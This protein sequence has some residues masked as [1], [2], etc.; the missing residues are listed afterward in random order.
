MSQ[1]RG[2]FERLWIAGLVALGLVFV[3]TYLVVALLRLSHPFELE[4]MEGAMVDHVLR[5]MSGDAL[6]VEPTLEF[7]PFIYP[8]G[9]YW[10]SAVVSKI[11]GEGFLPLRLVSI[12]ASIAG[13]A[14]LCA[15]GVRATNRRSMGLLAA[16]LFVA[17]YRRGDAWLDLGRVDS[18]FLALILGA[19]YCISLEPNLRNRVLAAVLL[20][21]AFVT[22]QTTL[23]IAG[24]LLV[25]AL[26]ADRGRIRF[27]LPALFSGLTIAF[28]L[29]MNSATNHWFG[30]Y[31]FV[32]PERHEWS[33]PMLTRFWTSDLF[34]VFL[35][36]LLLGSAGM[37]QLLRSSHRT[38]IVSIFALGIGLVGSSWLS[39]L[40][41]G[42]H[43]NVLI[44]A[45][46]FLALASV[47][48]LHGMTEGSKSFLSR[49]SALGLMTI[50]FALLAYD[51]RN[52][53]PTEA[54]V[55]AGRRFE[56]RLESVDGDVLIPA[57]GY[58]ATRM[59]KTMTAH[60]MAIF[61]VLRD[62]DDEAA[63]SLTRDIERALAAMRYSAIVLDYSWEFEELIEDGY[64][65]PTPALEDSDALIPVSGV[66]T[67][68]T[69]VYSKP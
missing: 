11:V 55:E 21:F 14:L 38:Q 64:A 51:P 8:P 54:D 10:I 57:H 3:A 31:V 30:Y 69:R 33:F 67:R 2:A 47:I 22:K 42:G 15:L 18:L 25:G 37:L 59:G 23:I 58:L 9:Y 1:Q 29:G 41:I 24:P 36:A 60:Q 52:A 43:T 6:Y 7:V 63:T 40:H 5:V 17:C 46:A 34:P 53:L 26:L 62:S 56:A 44:P 49:W 20:W 32:L 27:T 28:I 13:M 12:V 45:F 35:P 48:G 19:A 61:D 68:P 4:W 66:P 39:R 50:Q 16:G 65:P